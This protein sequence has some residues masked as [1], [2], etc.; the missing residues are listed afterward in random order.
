MAG[1]YT[2]AGT[3]SVFGPV[4]TVV[5]GIV[6]AGVGAWIGWNVVGP[7]LSSGLPPGFWPGDKGSAEWGRRNGVGARDGKGRFHGV[8]QGCPGSKP[9]D[10]Y[11][12][13][14]ATGDVVDPNGDVVGNLWDAKPK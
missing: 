3:G 14:P 4:G 9:T 8:K 11:G 12:V 10:N 2:G 1:A 5:G 13:N 7:M 6:G